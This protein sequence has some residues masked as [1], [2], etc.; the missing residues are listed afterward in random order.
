MT[1][2]KIMS[3]I[4]EEMKQFELHFKSNLQSKVPL[5]DKITHYI[6]KRKG[7]QM[8]PMFLF[9]TAK[10]LGE[11]NAKTYQAATLV[12]LL[13]T[14]T[15]VHD[16]VVDDSNERRG[17]FSINALWKNKI[18][19]LVGDYMLSRIL[20]LSIENKNIRVL[21]IV[22]RAV[23]EMS[24]GE[25]FEYAKQDTVIGFLGKKAD[26]KI[27][28]LRQRGGALDEIEVRLA[29]LQAAPILGVTLRDSE[30]L[31]QRC[32]NVNDDE[33][34]AVVYEFNSC[35]QDL[36]PETALIRRIAEH[37]YEGKDLRKFGDIEDVIK[38]SLIVMMLIQISIP[39][40]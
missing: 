17:F 38:K 6:I 4:T 21:E 1:V 27:E 37:I 14:A 35:A 12:E 32:S 39:L 20:L 13:H 11:I 15:L 7:K 23:R 19:V 18:A 40:A 33:L 36:D 5:L 26:D 10:M 2:E 34:S 24:E 8:R 22:A 16:D 31:Y 29:Y 28:T 30:M 25:F 9:L 3:P